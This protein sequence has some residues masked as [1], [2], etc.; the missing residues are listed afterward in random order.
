MSF[1]DAVAFV[2]EREGGLSDLM[3]DSGGLTK[4]GISKNNASSRSWGSTERNRGA[5]DN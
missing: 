1:D 3:G 5:G 4:F 2:L